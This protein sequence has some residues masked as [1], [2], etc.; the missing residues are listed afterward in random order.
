VDDVY[1]QK[2]FPKIATYAE[3]HALMLTLFVC[4]SS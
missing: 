1:F 4:V 2:D 3:Q